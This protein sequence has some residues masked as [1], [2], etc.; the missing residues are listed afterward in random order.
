MVQR[1]RTKYCIVVWVVDPGVKEWVI[2]VGGSEWIAQPGCQVFVG[3]VRA[4][5]TPCIFMFDVG[6][7][8]PTN[9]R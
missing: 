1:L 5:G 3:V 7:G 2:G 4:S 8:R 6:V 9:L